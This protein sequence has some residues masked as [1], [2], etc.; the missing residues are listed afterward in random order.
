MAVIIITSS[1]WVVTLSWQMGNCLEGNVGGDFAG[2]LSW[3][4][5]SGVGHV[6]GN[7]YV[8]FFPGV[9][10]KGNARTIGIVHE[11]YSGINTH[12]RTVQERIA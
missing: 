12:R 8:D 10:P 9:C 2:I 7:V 11:D 1:P 5:L 6:R 3:D 4:E